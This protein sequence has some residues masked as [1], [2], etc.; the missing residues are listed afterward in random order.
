MPLEAAAGYLCHEAASRLHICSSLTKSLHVVPR[1][2]FT[3]LSYLD[4]LDYFTSIFIWFSYLNRFIY[5]F[6]I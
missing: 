2:W 3:F 5:P 1:L 4:L 6:I